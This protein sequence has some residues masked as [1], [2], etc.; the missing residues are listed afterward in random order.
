MRVSVCFIISL[1]LI[2]ILIDS[3][4]LTTDRKQNVWSWLTL[5]QFWIVTEVIWVAW[6][7][8]VNINISL[9]VLC[10]FIFHLT[11]TKSLQR[12]FIK[13]L[14]QVI[15]QPR[16][17]R[18]KHLDCGCQGPLFESCSI[19]SSPDDGNLLIFVEYYNEKS[20][21]AIN[22]WSLKAIQALARS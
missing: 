14:L 10:Q 6:G 15:N 4:S 17:P 20:G 1:S 13:K 12:I 21:T 2:N 8:W 18:G 5:E 16:W 3:N 9:F 7:V 22:G 19:S 11:Q